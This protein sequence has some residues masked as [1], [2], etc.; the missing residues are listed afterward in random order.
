MLARVLAPLLGLFLA[1]FTAASAA[2]AAQS[3]MPIMLQCDTDPGKVLGMVSNQYG[4]LALAQGE[5]I[6]QSAISGRFQPA[7]IY[8]TVNPQTLSY[9]VIAVDPQSGTEC[10]L[11]VGSN[12]RPVSH[13]DPL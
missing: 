9:S 10:L 12:F 4:E 13:G 2:N 1:T 3:V 5:G 8:I 6:V 11:M 7:E